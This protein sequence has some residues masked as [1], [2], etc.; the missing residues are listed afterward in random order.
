M[1]PRRLA[2]TSLLV[3]FSLLGDSMLYVVLP[4]EA[5]SLGL[6]AS[7]IGWA[8]SINRWVRLLTNPIAARICARWGWRWPFLAAVVVGGATTVAYAIVGGALWPLLLARCLWGLCWS[9]LRQGGHSAVMEVSTAATRG[10]SMG[11]FT[12]IFRLGSLVG[13]VLGGWLYD[14]IG[15]GRTFILFGLITSLGVLV[16][17]LDGWLPKQEVPPP[18]EGAQAPVRSLF[19]PAQFLRSVPWLTVSTA[20]FAVHLITSGLVTSTLGYLLPERFGA[21][22]A[23]LTGTLLGIRWVTGL[24]LNPAMGILSDRLGRMRTLLIG[25]GL[26]AVGMVV[27]GGAPA[28]WLVAAGVAA[29]WAAESAVAISVDAAAGDL[30]AHDGGAEALGYYSTVLD[31]GAATGPLLGYYL[32]EGGISLTNVYIA[33]AALFLLAPL[34]YRTSRRFA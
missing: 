7:A 18:A 21:H 31:L 29:V 8:L 14:A 33:A 11:F 13:M 10:R 32:V 6:A 30:A 5:A 25:A 12:A 16:A 27:V 26:G 22:L 24:L 3:A 9:F 2:V 20:G 1:V 19:G 28:V 23:A 17:G 4:S 15:Y 34:L